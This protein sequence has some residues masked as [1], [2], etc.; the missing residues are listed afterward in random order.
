MVSM[1]RLKE[2]LRAYRKV[3]QQNWDLFKASKIGVVGIIIMLFFVG[4]AAITPFLGLRDPINWRAPDADIIHVTSWWGDGRNVTL[5]PYNGG[6]PIN[7]S[8]SFRVKLAGGGATEADRVYFTSGNKLYSLTPLGGGSYWDDGKPIGADFDF[9]HLTDSPFSTDVVVSNFGDQYD[10]DFVDYVL[11]V[12][13]SDG[14]IY[15]IDDY[16]DSNP[17]ERQIFPSGDR[18]Y[19]EKLDSGAAITSA[20]LF[21]DKMPGRRPN[22]R[23]YFG[24]DDGYLYAYSVAKLDNED[25]SYVSANQTWIQMPLKE[26]EIKPSPRTNFSMAY[27]SV[28]DKIVLFG[29]YDG[30]LNDETWI[31]DPVTQNWTRIDTDP[32]PS[33]RYGHSMAFDSSTG[34]V[35]L[36]GGIIDSWQT[37][38]DE[39]WTFDVSTNTWTSIDTVTAP[40]A[41]AF[42]AMSFDSGQGFMVLFGGDRGSTETCS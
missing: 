33:A 8:V 12:G 9:S 2:K 18:L 31:Y 17:D 11:G 13:T 25:W 30:L 19:I 5:A 35:V 21:S 29:G 41:R 16:A 3:F 22:E 28:N 26:G 36:F 20:A 38:S 14:Y 37:A 39:T 40:A 32:H 24:T 27:D 23:I 1:A 10:P 7:H 4:M 34:E 42:S 6:D 15:M